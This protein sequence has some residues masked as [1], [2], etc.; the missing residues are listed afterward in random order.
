[1]ITMGYSLCY[2]WKRGVGKVETEEQRLTNIHD[3][4]GGVCARGREREMGIKGGRGY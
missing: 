3:K 1:M 4:G 2:F